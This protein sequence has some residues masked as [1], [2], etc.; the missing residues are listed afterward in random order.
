LRAPLPDSVEQTLAIYHIS[1]TKEGLLGALQHPQPAARAFAAG[2]LAKS[3]DKAA[4]PPILS[5][6]AAETDGPTKIGMATAVAK[7]GSAEGFKAL[8]SMCG[9]RGWSPSLRMSA[10]QTMSVFLNS[11]EC[12]SDVLEVLWTPADHHDADMIALNILIQPGLF[13]QIS[14]SQLDE[15]RNL[16]I[17]YLKSQTPNVRSAASSVISALGGP[18][19]I[20]QLQAA[21]DAEQDDSVRSWVAAELLFLRQ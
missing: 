2:M 10:A 18:W 13:K 19:A 16:S 21:L 8:K 11:Q 9:D 4:I 15:I 20:A 3:E 6:L 17:V 7:L 12:L 14:P 1:P 5:A